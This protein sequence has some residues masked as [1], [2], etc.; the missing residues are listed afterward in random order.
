MGI[1]GFTIQ[2]KDSLPPTTYPT[3]PKPLCVYVP[4]PPQPSR[5]VLTPLSEF[6]VFV[7]SDLSKLED[8]PDGIIAHMRKTNAEIEQNIAI[9]LT[10]FLQLSAGVDSFP[11]GMIFEFQV[12]SIHTMQK[13]RFEV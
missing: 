10:T 4:P 8:L 11:E 9:H 13:S 6:T 3:Y 2:L 1:S 5:L 12:F 7:V